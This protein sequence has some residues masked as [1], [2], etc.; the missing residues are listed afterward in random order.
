MAIDIENRVREIVGVRLATAP[1]SEKA[2]GS[3]KK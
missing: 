3:E 1:A 2:K